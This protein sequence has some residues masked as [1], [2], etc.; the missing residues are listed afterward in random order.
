[1]EAP[2]S[3]NLPAVQPKPALPAPGGGGRKPPPPPP[4]EPEDEDEEGMLRMSF[5]EHLEELRKRILHMLGGVVIIFFVSLIFCN[6]L[7][8]LIAAPAVD[9]LTQL[10]V[11]P[12]NLVQI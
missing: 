4:E 10:G 3:A 1:P 2:P 12:P 5:M 7:W 9:A 11:K 8:D 6:Q